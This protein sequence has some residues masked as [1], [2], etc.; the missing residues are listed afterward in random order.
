MDEQNTP[1]IGHNERSPFVRQSPQLNPPPLPSPV[2]LFPVRVPTQL[3]P[4]SEP[5]KKKQHR[6][7]NSIKQKLAF[8]RRVD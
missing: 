4:N 1:D 2:S 8:L 3:L 5:A 6:K 7:R